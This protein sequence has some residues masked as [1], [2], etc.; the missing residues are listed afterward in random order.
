MSDV[1]LFLINYKFA[2][3]FSS[4]FFRWQQADRNEDLKS[5][6]YCIYINHGQ[7]KAL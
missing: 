5:A 4:F 1:P 6:I 2:I 3:R 7:N